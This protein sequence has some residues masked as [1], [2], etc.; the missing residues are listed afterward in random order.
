M[1]KL[2]IIDDHPQM[3]LLLQF[4]VRDLVQMV[5]ECEDGSQALAAYA[6][7]R[8]DWVFMDIEMKGMDGLTATSTLHRIFPDAKVIIITQHNDEHFR[9]AARQ[10]GACAYV[11]KENLLSLRPLLR[12]L[13]P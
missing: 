4:V 13:A 11:L 10:A 5:Y 6:L 7:Y 3:R 8:P 9:E 12:G 2:L 1:T